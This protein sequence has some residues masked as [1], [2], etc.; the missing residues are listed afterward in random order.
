MNDNINIDEIIDDW[1]VLLPKGYP[2]VE[3]GKFSDSTEIEILNQILK[4]RGIDKTISC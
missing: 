2:S 4:E 3:N 1:C